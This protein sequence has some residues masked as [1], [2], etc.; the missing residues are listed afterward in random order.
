MLELVL[1]LG[2]ACFSLSCTLVQLLQLLAQLLILC[3]SLQRLLVELTHPSDNGTWH[4][5]PVSE[6][7][8]L[9]GIVAPLPVTPIQEVQHVPPADFACNELHEM[10]DCE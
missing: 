2:N 7:A 4:L 10:I 1:Q 3:G 5:R 8:Q 9:D 6:E